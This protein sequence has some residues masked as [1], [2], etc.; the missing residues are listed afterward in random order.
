MGKLKVGVIGLGSRGFNLLQEI[1]LPIDSIE[2]TA[3][4]DSYEDRAKEGADEVEKKYGIRPFFTTD[5]F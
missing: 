2:V 4:C 5:G 1:I 3:V